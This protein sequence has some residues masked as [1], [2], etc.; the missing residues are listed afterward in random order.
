MRRETG[1]GRKEAWRARDAEALQHVV[2]KRRKGTRPIVMAGSK[3]D[4]SSACGRRSD[5][6]GSNARPNS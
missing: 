4:D 2:A 1:D 3:S 5:Q 6:P